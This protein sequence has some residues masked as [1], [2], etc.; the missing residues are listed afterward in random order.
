MRPADELAQEL[1]KELG[2]R[3]ILLGPLSR[4]PPAG[5]RVSFMS[6]AVTGKSV[7]HLVMIL[8]DQLDIDSVALAD[9][10]PAQDLVLMAEVPAESTHVWSSKPR[11]A[12]FLAAMRQFCR[13]LEKRGLPVRYL[14]LGEHRFDTL[15]D[16]LSDAIGNFKPRKVVMVEPG[17]WRVER[18]IETVCA[19]CNTPLAVRE[20][21]HFML[22]RREFA[23]W[24]TGYRQLRLE[25]F[26]R[27]MRKR[28]EVLM[29]GA[30]PLGGNWNFDA[31]NRG[32][33][34]KAGPGLMP[35]LPRF[36]QDAV[37]RAALGDIEKHF[38]GH[39]GSLARFNWPVDRPQ[40]LLALDDFIQHRLPQ[41]GLF[42]DAM[43]T[44]QPFLYHSLL[45]A[46]LNVKLLN[47]R[48]V[49]AA[50]VSAY[51]AGRA[52][53]EAVEGF[54]RQILG[55]REFI[56][57]VYWQDMPAMREAN[58]FGHQRDLPSWYWDGNTRMN[59]M[60]QVIGQTLDYGYAHHIQRLMVTGIWAL[61]AEITPTQIEDWYLAVYVDAVEWV[62]LPNVAG[63]A[64]YANG[65]RF[66]SKPYI[67]SG[68]YI[69]RMSNY[70]R[71]CRYQPAARTGELACPFTTL[72][73]NFLDKHEKMLVANPR[74][75]LMA[76]NVSRL[77]ADERAAIRQQAAAALEN[78]DAL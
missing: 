68:Q 16:A 56:R 33:F 18:Q 9:I 21:N 78:L 55:W 30:E 8:G 5:G 73:W 22:S 61:L 19:Q 4:R 51:H 46:A 2:K 58:H 12:Y 66:T 72:Y 32:A 77:T 11:S 40:A 17:D 6:E 13:A 65:G 74:T 27:M 24:T 52:P 15:A 63:M 28:H 29:A 10:D 42:Q 43:W 1:G 49:I 41:F 50:A 57:G 35:A 47:P 3:Q 59:C 76:K 53:I 23:E 75:S 14:A 45:S 39:P 37:T 36:A 71:G 26:Y 34:G 62:E 64:I 69:N 38:A 54:V 25:Y 44:D 60:K 48:E 20:D 31:D 7:R 70:C 67:A